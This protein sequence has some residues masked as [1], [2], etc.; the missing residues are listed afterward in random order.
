MSVL[1]PCNP[2]VTA[3]RIHDHLSSRRKALLSEVE[4]RL[5]EELCWDFPLYRPQRDGWICI[6]AFSSSHIFTPELPTLEY[7]YHQALWFWVLGGDWGVEFAINYLPP[8]T[9]TFYFLETRSINELK[10]QRFR[11]A[12]Q[13]ASGIHCL[14]LLPQ[15]WA[16]RSLCPA[17]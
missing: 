5:L 6:W 4:L 17:S 14:C 13:W 15:C 9:S 2:P 10:A 12:R 3:L 11:L 7:L 1:C 8:L 16:Y